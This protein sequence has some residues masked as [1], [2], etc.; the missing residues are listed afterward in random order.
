MGELQLDGTKL[1]YHPGLLQKWKE[2]QTIY[3]LL[4][5]I[6]PTNQ[7]NHGCT[8]CAYEY[9]NRKPG[10][11]LEYDHVVRCIG[12]LSALGTKS[13]FYSGEGEPL[14]Y[15][16][17]EDLVEYSA[18]KGFDQALNTNGVL[19]RD[20]RM[21]RLLPHMS[22]IRVS[23]NAGTREDYAAIHRTA[24]KD[25]DTVLSNL[26]KAV[27]YKTA[28]K[29]RVTL[30]V[31]LVYLDQS[32]GSIHG[33]AKQLKNIGV[34]Y[35]TVKRFNQHPAASPHACDLRALADIEKIAELN[36]DTFSARTR[37]N[38][39]QNSVRRTYTQCLAL[40]F[41]A[42]IISNGDVYSCGPYLGY[43]DFC[44]G[45]IYQ[46]DFKTLWQPDNRKKVTDKLRVIQNLDKACM[47][48]C[49]LDAANR[50]LWELANPPQ[51]INFI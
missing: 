37:F 14:L 6:S 31:Q 29:L 3:P 27:Q 43:P 9:L 35:F 12:E 2:G 8:F 20:R 23:L 48:S 42:E 47:P 1:G 24:P 30:G 15:K 36:D 21:E 22:W 33:L 19:L 13:L 4:V 7:C 26:E 41:F 18:R 45:N 5:E 16:K 44:Y 11:F 39:R 51:H 28:R 50:F 38:L 49:R 25:F 32:V 34:D 17:L 10:F 46:S 40:P